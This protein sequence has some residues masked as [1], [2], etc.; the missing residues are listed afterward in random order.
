LRT[1]TELTDALESIADGALS[2][3]Y[4]RVSDETFVLC[5]VCNRFEDHSDTCPVPAIEK[6]LEASE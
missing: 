6:W 1:T 5:H 4:D 2:R 3:H